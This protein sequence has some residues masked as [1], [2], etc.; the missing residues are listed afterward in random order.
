[1]WE[2]WG[3]VWSHSCEECSNVKQKERKNCQ[4]RVPCYDYDPVM[5][6]TLYYRHYRYYLS[7]W[8]ICMIK[9][10][11]VPS[12]SHVQLF[13]TPW[14]AALQASLSFAIFWSLH[15]LMSIE[16]VMPSNHLILCLPLFLLPW[17]FPNISV[18][19][20]EL[21]LHIR[22][23]EYWSFS[24]SISPSN[25]YSGL[26]S[27]RIDWFDLL[28]VQGT[29]KVCLLSKPMCFCP[30]WT[31]KPGVLQ[32]VGSERVWHYLAN[33]QRKQMCF[34][35]LKVKS[36][37]VKVLAAQLHLTLLWPHEL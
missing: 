24:F 33:G 26:I 5:Y 22:W 31:E 35:N 3:A 34:C 23:P 2:L 12:L 21:A 19:S 8:W 9:M 6:Q 11:V 25:E 30:T 36:E 32:F 27:F 7:S 4:V 28:T 13:V 29:T 16:S 18:F 17:S 20:K 1:M 14:T 37:K 15:K 10:V